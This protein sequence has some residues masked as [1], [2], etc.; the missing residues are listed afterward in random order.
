[1]RRIA[2]FKS[3]ILALA[4]MF[5][6][7]QL[8]LCQTIGPEPILLWPEGAPGKLGDEPLDK[9]ELRIYPAKK[10]LASGTGVIICP[11]GGY[12]ALA[13]D[14]EGHQVAKWFNSIG[15]TGFVL[16]YR[17]GPRY[18]HPAP[19]Q[20]V[21]RAIRFA[22]AN[23][24]QFGLSARRI[25]V[26]GF[27]AGGHLASTAATHFDAGKP[28]HID[29][30]ERVTCRPDFVVLGYPV[31]SFQESFSHRGSARNL[32]GENPEPSMLELLSNE[33][34]VTKDS[35]PAFLFH[36]GED[37]GVPVEN[38][39]AYYQACRKHGVPAELHVYRYGPHG[40]GLAPGDPAASTWKDRLADWLRASAL[41]ADVERAAV[42][43]VVRVDG[44]PLRW[45]MITFVAAD[46]PH[47]PAAFAMVRNGDFKVS[48]IS[49]AAVGPCKIEV[50]G[51]G[52]VEARPTLDDIRR[53]DEG[54]HACEVKAGENKIIVEIETKK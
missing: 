36:T 14:H 44:Q 37:T 6:G 28:D 41:L 52:A 46:S 8:A 34:Q 9:P 51:L 4:V 50:R 24:E 23:A 26:I 48:A 22:R 15:V 31:I 29:T 12:G 42:T 32:L 16:K 1:M 33:K 3:C 25:G 39:L 5:S 35:P 11:G 20:D 18:H 7:A 17:L 40:V 10:E 13:M 30:V 43:G 54:K 53:F 21:Q 38:S 47:K 49:G 45:G 27:S 2:F 19:L